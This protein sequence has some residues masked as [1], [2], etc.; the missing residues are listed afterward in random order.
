MMITV[1]MV[2][3]TAIPRKETKNVDPTKG[4]VL[5]YGRRKVGKTFLVRNFIKHDMYVLVKR[6]GGALIVGGPLKR[7]DDHGQVMEFITRALEDG[8]IVV[9]DEFQRLP[10]EFLDM[11][12]MVHPKGGLVLLG[13][14][15][16]VAQNLTSKKSPLLGL[17]SEVHLSL[18]APTDIFLGLSG[19]MPAEQAL[20]LSP[21]MR[22]PWA[23]RHLNGRPE[24]TIARVLEHSGSAVPALIG[25]VFLDEDR[26][27]SEVYESI[28]R[29]IASG[30]NTLK[31]VSDQLFSRKLIKAND[32]SQV[33]PY[34]KVMEG[35]DL[36]ERV[37]LYDTRG[38]FYSVRSKLM[39]L[40]YYLDEKYDI[41]AAR[42][43]LIRE[44]I[45]ERLPFH[46][47]FFVGELLAE[48]L[49][50]TFRYA[51]T[52]TSDL[53][54]VITRRNNPIFVGEVKWSRRVDRGD[55]AKFLRNCEAFKCRKA[56]I[57]KVPLD[58]DELEVLTPDKILEMARALRSD[59]K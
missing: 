2:T 46:V 51:I 49:D 20:A 6:G 36:I 30:K 55:V 31:E 32:P 47:Q 8:K 54:I 3:V 42:P 58:T 23:L 19:V 45:A 11:L 29:A 34:V 38:N 10:D 39:E 53:D 40:Y 21:Y 22:D 26:F 17:V 1:T 24:E 5:I 41:E 50:G 14:A 18:L 4:W 12:Q 16:H 52:E 35:M 9:V 56:L 48:L 28:V 57:S 25:E 44:V 13:S 33:R 59:L 43:S 15:M 7:T 27:L 37:P